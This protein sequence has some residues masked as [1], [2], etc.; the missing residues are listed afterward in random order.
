LTRA[1]SVGCNIQLIVD[2]KH[3]LWAGLPATE[4]PVISLA[5]RYRASS[6]TE[7]SGA[8]SE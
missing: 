5:G 6:I 3:T 1:T 2:G 7:E 8:V 4:I